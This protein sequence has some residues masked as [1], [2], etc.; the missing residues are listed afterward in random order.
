MLVNSKRMEGA[1]VVTQSGTRLGKLFSHEL[2]AETGKLTSIIVR[3]IGKV[4]AFLS[5]DLLIGW[6]QIVSMS[7]EK[8][9]VLDTAV[10]AKES[11]MATLVTSV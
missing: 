7:E 10:N 11:L 3:P 8:I 9:V 5:S 4:T 2:D 6:S 1:S